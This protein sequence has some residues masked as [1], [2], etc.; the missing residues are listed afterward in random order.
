MNENYS[1]ESYN[2]D[3]YKEEKNRIPWVRVI[4]SF[5]ILVAII[6]II[7][8]LLKACGKTSLRDDLIEAAKDYYEKYPDMLPSEVGECFVVTLADLEK[9]GLIKV[10]DYETCDKEKTYVN[11]CYLESKTYHYSAILEC[12]VEDT[13]YGMWQDGTEDDI[14]ETSDIRFKFLGEE[15]QTGT[16]Y[17]YPKDLTD[18]T[19]VIEYYAAIPKSGYTGKEDEQ[20]GYKW[21]TEE[22]VNK[23][24]NNGGYS[25]TQ[26]EGYPTKGSSTTVTKYSVTK[27]SSASY[28]KIENATLYR[29]QDVAYPYVWTCV[30]P[31]NPNDAVVSDVPCSGTHSKTKDIRFT[32]DGK[33]EVKV[34]AEQLKNMD[35]PSCGEWSDYTTKSCTTNYLNG[36]KCEKQSGYKYTDTMWKWYTNVTERSYYPSGASSASEEITYYISTPISGAIKDD[37]TGTTVYKYYRLAEGEGTTNYEEWLPITDGYVTLSEML[38]AFRE[39]KYEVYSLSDINQI[40]KIRYQYQMQYRDLEE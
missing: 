29:T 3:E 24:W 17:Y 2:Y 26:P 40:E 15:L 1:N 39:L 11:V 19:K 34:T 22:K 36:I 14:E 27:P 38:E 37:S 16:K 10:S 31:N 21:Y 20:F 35:F 25:S 28:R 9:E 6:I 33:T 13:N 23:Y 8:L 7:L 30:N 12:E 32:C 18:V 5:L 4:I